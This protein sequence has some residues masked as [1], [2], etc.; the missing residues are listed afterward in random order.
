MT[1][2]ELRLHTRLRKI[3][4]ELGTLLATIEADEQSLPHGELAERSERVLRDVWRQ[5]DSYETHEARKHDLAMAL[6]LDESTDWVAMIGRVKR[7]R[8]GDRWKRLR[9]G[10]R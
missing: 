7:L 4:E 10:D 1:E 9:D 2:I 6:G 3:R 8:D 5:E